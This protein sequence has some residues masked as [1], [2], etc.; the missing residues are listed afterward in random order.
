MGYQTGRLVGYQAFSGLSLGYS[1]I[2]LDGLLGY[3]GLFWAI[4]G[5]S[6]ILAYWAI[7]LSGLFLGYPW[8]VYGLITGYWANIGLF[9]KFIF[10]K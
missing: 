7:G 4:L 9:M 6:T 1:T 2:G 8:V 3:S 5:Y 10:N